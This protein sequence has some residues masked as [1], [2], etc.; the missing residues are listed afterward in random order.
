MA[1]MDITEEITPA[2]R[3]PIIET[4]GD[5]QDLEIGEKIMI[6]EV[7]EEMIIIKIRFKFKDEMNLQNTIIILERVVKSLLETCLLA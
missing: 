7:K 3:V 6:A 1:E 5:A 4:M 2:I